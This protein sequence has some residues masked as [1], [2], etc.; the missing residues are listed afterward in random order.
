[1]AKRV[2]ESG[3]LNRVQRCRSRSRR[4]DWVEDLE[5]LRFRPGELGGAMKE[6]A[7]DSDASR[8]QELVD[9]SQLKSIDYYEVSARRFESESDAEQSGNV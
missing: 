4:E 8:L 9:H 7:Q 1:M 3:T 6:N 2:A 5:S